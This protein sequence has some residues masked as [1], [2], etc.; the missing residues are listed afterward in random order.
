MVVDPGFTRT[1]AKADEH[2]S[3]PA[4]T[5][6]SFRHAV[7]HLQ[8]MAGRHQHINDRVYGWTRSKQTSYEVDARQGRRG[9]R[10]PEARVYMA[11]EMMESSIHHRLHGQTQHT[12]GRQCH[13]SCSASSNWRR[14]R[15]QL[16]VIQ[17]FSAVTVMCRRYGCRTKPTPCL[18]TS[19]IGRRFVEAL[20]RQ[21][22][23]VDFDWIRPL[24]I[25]PP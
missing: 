2:P 7:P 5:F 13:R 23:G 4:S 16:V 1:A 6:R 14:Q 15:R 24:F 17:H 11:A 12:T 9:L 10:V 20:S 22:W 19:R 3:V 25:T 18:A 21:T 8:K